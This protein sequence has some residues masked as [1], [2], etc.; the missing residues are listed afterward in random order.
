MFDVL[1]SGDHRFFCQKASAT[2]NVNHMAVEEDD[3]NRDRLESV[4]ASFA[5]VS[6]SCT[7]DGVHL[8]RAVPVVRS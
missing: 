8:N 6:L 1:G 4:R 2:K 7:V 3:E 5:R